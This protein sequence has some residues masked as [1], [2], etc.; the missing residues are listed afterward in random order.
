MKT[1]VCREPTCPNAAS[2][3]PIEIYSGPGEYC[4]ECGERL[5]PVAAAPV[6]LSQ[7]AFEQARARMMSSL[8]PAAPP[9]ARP[10]RGAIVA[11]AAA[12]LAVGAGFAVLRTV[13]AGHSAAGA[14][15]VCHSDLTERLASDV[16]RSYAAKSGTP[17]SRFAL[18]AG[19]GA[20]GVRF[21]ARADAKAERGIAHDGIVA[22]V[23]PQNPLAR[24]SQDQ[25]RRIFGGALTDW[26]RVGGRPGA[27]AALLPDDAT[28]E[29]R[30]LAATLLRGTKLGRD[31][32][33]LPSS[34]EIVRAVAGAR[35]RATIGLVAF[36]AAVPA[37]VLALGDAPAPS[38]LS[39]ANHR[40]PLS[41]TIAVD[42]EGSAHEAAA[43]GLVDYARSDEAQSIVVRDGL[44]AKKGF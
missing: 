3:E 6:P 19:E 10:N 40:Y 30:A 28:D 17:A 2:A 26:S 4:P 7:E 15:H 1:G 12:V 31:V 35:G 18:D 20:C 29:G 36:S 9:R 42:P 13:A 16:V 14:V 22:V 25:L 8:A 23:N 11:I 37:K 43:D 34:A 24:L 27:I 5:E 44:V 32:R 38:V 21:S 41:L 39:I 33:R